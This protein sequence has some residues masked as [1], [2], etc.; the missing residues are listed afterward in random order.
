[1][2]DLLIRHARVVDGS[3]GP[4]FTADV[5]IVG[6]RIVALNASLSEEATHIIDAAGQVLAPGFVDAHTLDDLAILRISTVPPKVCQGITTV[7]IG[8]CGFG[9]APMV[10]EYAEAVQDYSAAVLG[11]D[12]Q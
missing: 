4:A 2:Y 3:G 9:L 1:M 5:G 11:K 7:V 10:P 8:N 12:D 6:E